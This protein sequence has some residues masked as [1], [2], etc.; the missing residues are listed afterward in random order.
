MSDQTLPCW[1]R[2][3]CVAA[4][5]LVC[6]TLVT[7]LPLQASLTARVTELTHSIDVSR[8]R[9]A[10]QQQEYQQALTDL[11]AVQS[12]LESVRPSAQ[13][14][15]QREQELRAQRKALRAE[16][17]QLA[18]QVAGL[19]AELDENADGLQ[20]AKEAIALLENAQADL[21]KLLPTLQ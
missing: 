19:Q 18:D 16:N 11:P 14:V 17:Q 5:L 15:Y 7:Q 10:K 13:A 8:Q 6:L 1:F 20:L 3:I 21:R 9:L 2:W 4:M 12:E